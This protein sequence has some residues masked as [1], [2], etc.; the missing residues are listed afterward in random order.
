MYKNTA[1]QYIFASVVD[2]SDGS[3]KTTGVDFYVTKDNGSQVAADS[4]AHVGNGQW[5]IALTQA[6]TN[7]DVL[8]IAWAGTDVVPGNITVYPVTTKAQDLHNFDP[9]SDQVDVNRVNG[10]EIDIGDAEV[11][12][13]ASIGATHAEVDSHLGC[14]PGD[15]I[16]I[17]KPGEGIQRAHVVTYTV[18]GEE[19][20]S[21][22]EIHFAPSLDIALETGVDAHVLELRAVKAMGQVAVQNNNDKTDYGLANNAI[23]AAKIDTNALDGKGDWNTTTPPTETAIRQE[24]DSNS[25]EL[26][27]IKDQTDKINTL[28]ED[29]TGLRF[30]EKALEQA[31]SGGGGDSVWNTTQRDTVLGYDAKIDAIQTETDKLDFTGSEGMLKSESTNMRGTDGAN[32]VA[33]DNATTTAINNKLPAD[34]PTKIDRLDADISSRAAAGDQMDL[35]N[36]PNANAVSAIQSGLSTFDGD[37]STLA[38]AENLA[39]TDGKIDDLVKRGRCDIKLNMATTPWEEQYYESGTATLLFAKKLYDKDG[40]PVTSV[41]TYAAYKQEDELT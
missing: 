34:T 35:I 14:E 2:A 24:I 8:G 17:R 16:L 36:A 3:T 32:T 12:A 4:A 27:A 33:P 39:T 6:E 7:A 20:V 28:T 13:A 23:T 25:V 26:A 21:N 19:G 1:G 18:D 5:R 9:V 30:T 11:Q 29:V 22:D 10:R 15:L 37:L 40:S 31:P 41:S 38:T